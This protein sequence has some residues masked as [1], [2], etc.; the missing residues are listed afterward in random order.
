MA[1]VPLLFGSVGML[2]GG[3]VTDALTKKAG[4]RWG[5][6]APNALSKCAAAAAFLACLWL[7]SAWGVVAAMAVMAVATDLAVPSVWAFAQDVGGRHA[8]SA[9]GW[10]NMWGNFGA[11]LSPVVLAAAQQSGGWDVAFLV[12]ATSFLLA[13]LAAA[14]VDARKPLE[15][16]AEIAS[17]GD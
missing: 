3:W 10:T 4:L 11:A 17:T 5:R 2:A 8:G 12:A 7:H 9:L 16:P 1:G 13:G 6:A 15:P 14:S